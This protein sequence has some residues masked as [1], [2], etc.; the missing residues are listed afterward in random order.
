VF[1]AKHSAAL[2]VAAGLALGVASGCGDDEESADSDVATDSALALSVCDEL[3]AYNNALVAV[4][5]ESVA[6]IVSSTPS[7]RRAALDAGVV[8]AIEVVRGW[9]GRIDGLVLGVG[10]EADQIRAQLDE[11]A[12]NAIDEL[13]DQSRQ[14]AGAGHVADDDVQG[15][16]GIWF[17]SIEKVMSVSEPTIFTLERSELKQAFLDEPSCRNVIQPFVND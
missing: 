13:D 14:S 7:E 1:R 9:Q 6:G 15:E 5:N 2:V 16:V 3:R 11:G 12:S 10:D 17:N 8:S 4:V